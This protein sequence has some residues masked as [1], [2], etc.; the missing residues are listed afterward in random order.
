MPFGY[1]LQVHQRVIHA[2]L[3]EYTGQGGI[4]LG[5]ARPIF[6]NALLL[7]AVN[8]LLRFAST[9]FQVFLSGR[10][11]PEGI[12]LLQLVLSVGSLA[13]TAGMGGIRTATMYL[14][15]EVVGKKQHGNMMWVLS[16]CILYSLFLS[17]GVGFLLH[18]FAP[19]IAEKWI[20]N[21]ST[22]GTIRLLACFLPVSCLCGV[23]VGYFTGV[24]RIGTLAAV[25]VVEQLFTM[26]STVLL[27][28]FWAH[29]DPGR[30]CCAVIMGSGLGACF[31]LTVLLILKW[32]EY[33]VNGPRIPI[34]M[35]LIEVAVPLAF[36]DD[37][38]A[39]ISTM[40]NLMVPKRLAL[41]P[42]EVVPLAAFGMVCGMVFP[43]LMFPAAILFGLAELLIPE[44]ARCNA[45]GSQNRIRHLTQ[46]SL[47]LALIY[48]CFCG[49]LLFLAADTLCIKFYHTPEAGAHLRRFSILAPMLYCDAIVDAITKGLGQQKICVRY[50]IITS[51]MDVVLLFILL[52]KYGM[53]GYFFSFFVTHLI[54]FFL[55]LHLLQTLAGKCLAFQTAFLCMIATVLSVVAAR[56]VSTVLLASIAFILMFISL[57]VLLRIITS[58]DMR[59]VKGLL[60]PQRTD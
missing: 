22:I 44:L 24:G 43:I 26:L 47:M 1:P 41:Y 29:N 10:I 11:G 18:R 57:L 40:E 21:I 3:S 13:M 15:A 33:T 7:T 55:S 5:K 58:E 27:L 25:E 28:V 16:G 48:G 42:G 49:G 23:M 17:C 51:A 2:P 20:G 12:G 56:C 14:C 46:K 37:V 54:N 9:S 39:G 45:A 19:L 4:F 38:K 36:A 52:P 31:T 34:R 30:A 50:N 6:Y 8:L 35:K 60:L 53:A 32:L 59:W